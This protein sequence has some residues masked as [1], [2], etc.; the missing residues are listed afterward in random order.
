MKYVVGIL[1]FLL[2]IAATIG[3]PYNWLYSLLYFVVSIFVAVIALS[4]YKHLDIQLFSLISIAYLP[5]IFDPFLNALLWKI[6]DILAIVALLCNY[7]K[8]SKLLEL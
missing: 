1:V 8:I 7:P 5:I 2:G 6:W 3:F 4:L